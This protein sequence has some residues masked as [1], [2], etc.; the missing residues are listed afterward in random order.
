MRFMKTPPQKPNYREKPFFART[1]TQ[2]LL[3]AEI[4]EVRR[5]RQNFF[6]ESQKQN[7]NLNPKTSPPQRLQSNSEKDCSC[8]EQKPEPDLAPQ[9]SARE[10]LFCL[11]MPDQKQLSALGSKHRKALVL[12]CG[13]TLCV[14]CGEKVLALGPGFSQR[15]L[16]LWCEIYLS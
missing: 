14:L 9:R 15:K 16:S 6:C 8:E 7:P 3:T 11:F 12:L 1:K 13:P 2:T 10:K 5:E 4:A